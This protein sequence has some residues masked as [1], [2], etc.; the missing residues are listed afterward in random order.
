M[1]QLDDGSTEQLLSGHMYPVG[2][3]GFATVAF[4][5]LFYQPKTSARRQ[6]FLF[7]TRLYAKNKKT[8]FFSFLNFDK[9]NYFFQIRCEIQNIL[10][11]I[12]LRVL[13][14]VK[15]LQMSKFFLLIKVKNW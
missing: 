1:D 13:E 12:S 2:G 5:C 4:F 6:L 14:R 7:L 10:L 15:S 8:S 3:A 11:D 9:F